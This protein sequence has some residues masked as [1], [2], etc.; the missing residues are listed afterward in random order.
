M[1]LH[2]RYVDKHAPNRCSWSVTWEKQ[3]CL[4]P[5]SWLTSHTETGLT[6]WFKH[7]MSRSHYLVKEE[8]SLTENITSVLG[9]ARASPCFVKGHWHS[10]LNPFLL[11]TPFLS[12]AFLS[13]ARL[14]ILC[15]STYHS[16]SPVP[17]LLISL[18]LIS[19]FIFSSFSFCFSCF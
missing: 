4:Q 7:L 13:Q 17:S 14:I 2:S 18:C 3:S 11:I 8:L 19:D 1:L 12:F 5:V 6:Y 15:L 16:I 10:S 9:Q